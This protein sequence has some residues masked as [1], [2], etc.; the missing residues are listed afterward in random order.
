MPLLYAVGAP[1]DA[2]CRPPIGGASPRFLVAGAPPAATNVASFP[3]PEARHHFLPG[4]RRRSDVTVAE[5]DAL[6]AAFCA[7][8]VDVF[9]RHKGAYGWGHKRLVLV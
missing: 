9:D 7:A 4:T 6:H 5:V 3:P 1:L 8:L 2:H